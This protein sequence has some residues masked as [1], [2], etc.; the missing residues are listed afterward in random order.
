MLKSV[1]G[2]ITDSSILSFSSVQKSF[3]SSSGKYSGGFAKEN[4]NKTKYSSILKIVGMGILGFVIL[5]LLVRTLTNSNRETPS[6]TT[7]TSVQGAKS[8]TDIQ[9]EFQF[10]INGVSEEENETPTFSYILESAE[11]RDEIVVQGQKA[12]AIKGRTFLII[13]L[14][15][16]NELSQAIQINTR[17]FIRIS[18]DPSNDE[19]LAPEIHNDPVEIQA[20]STKN[21]RVGLAI[22]SGVKNIILRVGEIDGEK[23]MVELSF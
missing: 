20:I 15:I 12:T 6:P 1:A 3:T 19:W 22:D 9:R 21:T 5:F 14:K 17:N 7:K 10:P 23:E 4:K 2:S 11:L 13:N 8:V 18:T 16:R